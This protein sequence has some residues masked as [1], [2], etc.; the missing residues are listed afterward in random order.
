MAAR[1]VLMTL[2]NSYIQ[3]LKNGLKRGV[4]F[5]LS[6]NYHSILLSKKFRKRDPRIQELFDRVFKN[7]QYCE[8]LDLTKADE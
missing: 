5:S 2:N 1:R 3:P 7:T 6:A 4:V 8:Y